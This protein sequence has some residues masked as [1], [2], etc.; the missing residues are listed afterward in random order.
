MSF[1][2]NLT[3]EIRRLNQD[4]NSVA[5]HK[6]AKELREKLLK[7]GIP[8]AVCGVLGI[9]GCMIAF[10]LIGISSMSNVAEFPTLILIPFFLFLP[11]GVVMMVGLTLTTLGLKIVVVGYTS[12]F[13]DE[14]LE[15]KCP[16]CGDKITEGEI[17]CTECGRPL[18]KIC[19]RCGHENLMTSK[20]CEKCGNKLDS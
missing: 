4:V 17:F 2:N 18:K 20:H 9:I 5:N 11:S 6:R 14:V 8:T 3:E 19:S 15:K 1:F 10:V 12:N 16:Y 7:I 13:I